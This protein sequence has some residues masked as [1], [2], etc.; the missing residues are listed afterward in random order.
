V[1]V[2]KKVVKK[3]FSQNFLAV[4]VANVKKRNVINVRV[5]FVMNMVK[6]SNKDLN[7]AFLTF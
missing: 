6:K 1:N 3:V 2:V 4:S 7:F 5:E